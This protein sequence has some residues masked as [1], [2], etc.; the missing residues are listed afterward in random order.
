MPSFTTGAKY[1]YI[2][3]LTKEELIIQI[4]LM[5]L[6]LSNQLRLN[7]LNDNYFILTLVTCFVCVSSNHCASD[8]S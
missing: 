3:D 2:R 8:F 7:M 5:L 4:Y 1:T 6:F